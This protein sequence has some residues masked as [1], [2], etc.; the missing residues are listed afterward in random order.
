MG[1]GK[2][3]VGKK[4]LFEKI[5]AEISFLVFFQASIMVHVTKKR[6]GERGA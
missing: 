3:Y 6:G 5:E 1:G 4:S 2:E